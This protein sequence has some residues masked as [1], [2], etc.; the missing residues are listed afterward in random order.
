MNI[1]STTF[2]LSFKSEQTTNNI[3]Q[4]IF[5]ELH[6]VVS[7]IQSRWEFPWCVY[8]NVTDDKNKKKKVILKVKSENK[9]TSNIKYL[10]QKYLS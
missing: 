3:L 6:S 9:T 1:L 7:L 2:L 10:K 4:K 8:L 5:L